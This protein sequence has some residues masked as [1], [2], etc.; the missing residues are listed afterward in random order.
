M[1]VYIYTLYEQKDVHLNLYICI[2]CI[3]YV[4]D[5]YVYILVDRKVDG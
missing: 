2:V 3:I 1:Y 4:Y 5:V